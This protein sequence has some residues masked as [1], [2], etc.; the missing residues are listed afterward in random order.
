MATVADSLLQRDGVL[1]FVMDGEK[2]DGVLP[3][4]IRSS[5]VASISGSA[6]GA[7]LQRQGQGQGHKSGLVYS[8]VDEKLQHGV[9]S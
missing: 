1:R 4:F 3:E 2:A 5:G 9:L 8:H 6:R 7:D